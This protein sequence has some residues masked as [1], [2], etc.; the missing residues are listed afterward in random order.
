[1]HWR[2]SQNP[3]LTLRD[4]QSWFQ[5]HPLSLFFPA[6]RNC[7]RR[8]PLH[9]EACRG[10][11]SSTPPHEATEQARELLVRLIA[12]GTVAA[13]NLFG[14][15]GEPPDFMAQAE[16]LPFVVSLRGDRDWKQAPDKSGGHKISPLVLE[17]VEGSG[18]GG[19][20]HRHGG[21][22]E[23]WP[24]DHRGSRVA[25]L[26]RAMAI[27]ARGPGA[28]A[29]QASRRNGSYSKTIIARRSPREAPPRR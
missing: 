15:L 6:R 29:A 22:G 2:Q 16:I 1:M 23:A 13:L 11:S 9:L 25:R 24:G 28:P 3:I 10:E 21:S 12:S 19:S 5:Q 8:R 26:E 4:S 20:A 17:S 7:R 27:H 14:S 18:A